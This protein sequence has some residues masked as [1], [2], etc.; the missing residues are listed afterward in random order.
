MLKMYKTVIAKCYVPVIQSNS[1]DCID[2]VIKLIPCSKYDTKATTAQTCFLMKVGEVSGQ[3]R[4][5]DSK[6]YS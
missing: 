2:A 1:L 4:K 3:H 5:I 6:K